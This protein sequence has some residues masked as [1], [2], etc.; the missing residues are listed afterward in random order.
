MYCQRFHISNAPGSSIK[1]LVCDCQNEIH[2]PEFIIKNDAD[3]V[4][5]WLN[6]QNNKKNLTYKL[7]N[8]RLNEYEEIILDTEEK[9][10]SVCSLNS[11]YV[12]L[13]ELKM[14]LDKIWGVE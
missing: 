10:A 3:K 14:E 6:Q 11:E 2:L 12:L 9:S 1:Y 4:C 5:D 8:D 7:I 13:K